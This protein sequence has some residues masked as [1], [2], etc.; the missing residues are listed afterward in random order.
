MC[1]VPNSTHI[2]LP[3][4]V[5]Y[6]SSL[7]ANWRGVLLNWR[8]TTR[9]RKT[10]ALPKNAFTALI[11]KSLDLGSLQ[12]KANLQAGFKATGIHPFNRQEVFLRLPEYAKTKTDVQTAKESLGES[13]KSYLVELREND[14]GTK[15]LRKFQM[16][17]IAGKSVSVEEVEQFY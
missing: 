11:K 15:S 13:F 5:G 1:L 8:E 6:F 9:G 12:C 7:K 14:L 17:I 10:V 3:L 2:Y 16:P 4:D